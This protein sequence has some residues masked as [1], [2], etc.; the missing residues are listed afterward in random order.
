MVFNLVFGIPAL[1]FAM[2]AA[3]FA[4]VMS[5][6]GFS[7][8]FTDKGLIPMATCLISAYL[9]SLPGVVCGVLS[10]KL[11]MVTALN[12]VSIALS[13]ASSAAGT[14]IFVTLALAVIADNAGFLI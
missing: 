4:S 7:V 3:S 5:L 11:G 9:N 8:I 13:I 2:A 1:I 14:V 12:K 10:R 6:M